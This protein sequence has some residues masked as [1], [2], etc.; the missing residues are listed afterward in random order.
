MKK[1]KSIF[2]IALAAL[3]TTSC[4]DF[5]TLMPL[6]DIVLENFWTDK[7]D[8]E[9]VLLGAYSALEKSDCVIRMSIWGE[10]RSDN[11]IAGKSPS[12]DILQ[13]TRDNILSTNSYTTYKCFY[14]VINRAN[15][16][17][18][19]APEVSAKDPNYTGAELQANE[20][21]AIAIRSLCYW[22]LIRAY[23]DVPYTTIPS[24]DDTHDFFIGQ[25]GFD[26]VLDSLIFDLERVKKYAVN[27]YT[28]ATANTG[29]FT[30]AAIYAMLADMYLWKGDWDKV[31]ENCEWVT[32][33]KLF[34][35]KEKLEDEG[36]ACTVELIN[37]YPLITETPISATAGNAYNE[38]FGTGNSFETLFELPYDQSTSNPF[39]SS[40]YNDKNSAVGSLKAVPEIGNSFGTGSGNKVFP[41]ATDGR[42]YQCIKADG[43]SGDYGIM[44]YVYEQAKYNLSSGLITWESGQPVKRNNTEPNWIVYRYTDVL[45]MEAEAKVM[46]AAAMGGDDNQFNAERDQLFQEAFNLVDA[47]NQ[48]AICKK[49]YGEMAK[50]LVFSDYNTSAQTMEE[51]VLAER[52]RELMF[53]GKRWFDLVRMARRDGNTSRLTTLVLPK[54]DAA[55]VSAVR[56]KMTDMNALYFPLN[57]DEIKINNLLKQNPVYVE[58]EFIE[59]ATH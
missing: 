1:I 8:V 18:H 47:V 57:K 27:K 43:S 53:E 11:I 16:V 14:D 48:R 4:E 21:E 35:Y 23:K 24:I 30:R 55:T 5:L 26:E 3:T 42:Y 39:V 46:K 51:L 31:I 12:D 52:R 17:L 22:Y 7:S 37:G 13:I 9:S 56:I 40:Y 25:T 41:Q 28:L 44:K 50:S 45:L 59:K 6:N 38:I 19:F 20:A 58:D 33:R 54:F 34:E 15:T 10:M 49:R 32:E 2:C 36:T 29:R